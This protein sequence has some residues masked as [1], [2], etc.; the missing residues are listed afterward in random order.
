MPRSYNEDLQFREMWMKEFLGYSIDL[1]SSG[2]YAHVA[3]N[4]PALCAKMPQY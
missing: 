4:Y 2:H 1:I 3:K